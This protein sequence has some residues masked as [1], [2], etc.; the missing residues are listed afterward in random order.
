MTNEKQKLALEIMALALLVD[1][2]TDYCV[3]IDYSGHVESMDISIRQDKKNYQ[4]KVCESK[5]YRIFQD[6]NKKGDAYAS[7]KSRR[8]VLKHILEE[9]EIPYH[10]MTEHVEKISHWEF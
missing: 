1:Q 3:F 5:V 7:L 9:K 2:N 4:N 6:L 8:D 10:E